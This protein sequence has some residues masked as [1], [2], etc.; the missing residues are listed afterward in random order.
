MSDTAQDIAP[1]FVPFFCSRLP[2]SPARKPRLSSAHFIP[3]LVLLTAVAFPAQALTNNLALTPPM[4]WNSWNHFGCNVSDATIRGIADAIATNGMKAAG[5]Q[6]INIDD[7]WQVTRDANGV[8][9][10]DP[11]RFPY[12]IQGLAAYVHSKGLKLGVYSDHG[13]TTCGG[14]PGGYGYEY[15]DANTYAS[16][17]VDYLKYDNCNL[18][19]GDVSQADYLRMADGLMRSRRPITFSICAWSFASWMPS[20]GNLWRT[21]GDIND[22]FSSM[23]SNLGG[24][25]PSAFVA[26][27]GRWNDPDM[28]EVGNGGMT[29]TEDQAHFTLWCIIGAPLIAGNDLTSVSAQTMS[30]F[31]NAELIAVD[32]DPGGE[33]GVMVPTSST[34]QVWV[35]PL[36]TD[37]TTKAVALFNPNTNGTTITVN[38]SDIGLRPGMATVRDMWAGAARGTFS[39][40]FSTNVSAHGAVALK[41]VGTAPL[42]PILGTNYLTAL[43]PAYAYVGWGTLG[44]NQTIGGNPIRLNGVTYTN[45]LGAHAFSGIEYRLGGIASRFQSDIG[46]DDE[47]GAHGS[48]VFQVLADGAKIFDSG[49]LNGSAAH[50]SIDLDVS[51]VN[52]LTLGVTDAGDGNSYDHADWAGAHVVVSNT[53]PA[54]PLAP[55]GLSATP[56]IPISLSWSSTRSALSYNLKRG[57]TPAGPF[58]N[59]V[60]L[61]LLLFADTNVIA[62]TTYYYVVSAVSVFG[63]GLNSAPASALACAPPAAPSGVTAVA[64]I[65][66]VT[67]SWNPVP[68]AASYSLARALPSTPYSVIAAGL[69]GTN[70]LDLA[71]VNAT[72]YS[73]V[74]Y[75]TNGCTQS[76]PS[77]FANAT[78]NLPPAAPTGLT[79]TTGGT[80]I[81]IEWNAAANASGYNLKRATNSAGPFF[82]LATNATALVYLDSGLLAGTTY[83]YVV[84]AV[85]SGGEGPDSVEAVATT[86]S[87]GLPSGW[88]DQDIGGVG[89]VGSGTGCGSSFVVQGGGADIWASADA[90]NFASASLTGNS[91]MAVQVT[92]LQ[93]TDPWAKAGVMYRN[94]SS[95]GSAFVDM[96]VSAANGVSLQWRS[97]AGGG[98]NAT[99][100]AGVAAPAW[101]ELVRSG[102]TFTGYY[103][104]DG[105]TWNPAGSATVT[106]A[107]TALAGLAVTAHNNSY[108]CLAAFADAAT[109]APAVPEGLAST[110]NWSQVALTWDSSL[111]AA[112][113]TLRRALAA[114]GP[115]TNL[116]TVSSM[117]Y[118]DT[119]V[120]NGTVYYYE[121]SASNALGSSAWSASVSAVV[122]LPA[123]SALVAGNRLVLSWPATA[124]SFAL[125]S[126]TNL[127]APVIWTTVTN[128]TATTNGQVTVTLVPSGHECFYRL[129]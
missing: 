9:V 115:Y 125:A 31:T 126:A 87:G 71:V 95:A 123:L 32:Q 24:N 97:T 48:V 66:L 33:Q 55:A 119:K 21:T 35:K 104:L 16:W 1:G 68:G 78:P 27:A 70:Y 44:I 127:L 40:S 106:L 102:N 50:R 4:G 14:R 107:T 73:Y 113:Y 109:V 29:F 6:F 90:F 20:A 53:A 19:A 39:N 84:S 117:S 41:I 11:T 22:S 86:C 83:Y 15:L 42:P 25:S 12:G 13:L 37:F 88:T 98:C 116:A 74:V 118:A 62:G 89:F 49:T 124:S 3:L 7:C 18:P 103:S 92:Y 59:L 111:G 47:V 93:E 80:R 56:G 38:W 121:V 72:N 17:G 82:I 108:L 51:G 120:A 122:P 10:P 2:R 65:Q 30:I 91:A 63:E 28:L 76:G 129:K 52:R 36:G 77:S 23:T 94:D 112:G 85:N 61:A 34:N 99:N 58:T 8:I 128:S 46:V 81:V 114:S 57:M 69:T 100:T 67:L 105:L 96:V 75:A 79:A 54:A 45:G 43:Q 5:Y 110:P 101:V 60:S 64:G 26:G